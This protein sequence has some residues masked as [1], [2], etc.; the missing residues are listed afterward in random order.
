ME[1]HQQ[2]KVEG[3]KW[4][5]DIA[6]SYTIVAVLIATVVFIA[7]FTVLGVMESKTNIPVF[8]GNITS[9][10]FTISDVV[11]LFTSITSLLMFFSILTSQYAEEDFLYVLSKRLSIGLL[12]LFISITSMLVAFSVTP[13]LEMDERS[14]LLVPITALACLPVASFERLQFPLLQDM[15]HA[16][17]FTNIFGKKSKKIVY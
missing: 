5:K 17:Y 4:M 9:T 6:N 11:S 15:S 10:L 3:E 1:K 8:W 13:D 7:T 16:R 2:L 12:I 14:Y